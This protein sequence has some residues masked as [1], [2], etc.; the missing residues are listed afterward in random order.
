MPSKPARLAS[1][2]ARRYILTISDG[3]LIS[4]KFAVCP[5]SVH[6]NNIP[7]IAMR[8]SYLRELQAGRGTFRPRPGG[9]MQQEREA[10]FL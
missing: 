10:L 1:V 8:H 6:I 2:T 4:V 9:A 5:F 7:S 3:F